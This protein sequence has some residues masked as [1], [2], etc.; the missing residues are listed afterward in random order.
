MIPRGL[1]SLITLS[2]LIS[3]PVIASAQSGKEKAKSV[4]A[5]ESRAQETVD[6][7]TA[8]QRQEMRENAR[9]RRQAEPDVLVD[10]GADVEGPRDQHKDMT[11]TADKNIEARRN[12]EGEAAKTKGNERAQEMRARRDERK[13]I[14]EEYKSDR[15]AGQEADS[16]PGSDDDSDEAAE[17]AKEKPKKSWWKFWED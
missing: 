10:E 8:E 5:S 6:E 14:Q 1:I 12:L 11:D 9:A 2:F 13:T 17:E 4:S 3:L 16:A 15:T 7:A